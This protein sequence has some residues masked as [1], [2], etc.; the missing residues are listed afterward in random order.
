LPGEFNFNTNDHIIDKDNL[1]QHINAI[2]A[3][4]KLELLAKLFEH[5]FSDV[6]IEV[7][8][9]EF[10]SGFLKSE[11]EE[12]YPNLL[13]LFFPEGAANHKHSPSQALSL[14]N[15]QRQFF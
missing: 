8:K 4:P 5:E 13:E 11:P 2:I 9:S 1:L 12:L 3:T 7:R 14:C 6:Q 10:E 15:A